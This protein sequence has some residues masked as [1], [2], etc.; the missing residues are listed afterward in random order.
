MCKYRQVL[1]V[2]IGRYVVAIARTGV[3]CKQVQLKCMLYLYYIYVLYINVCDFV[4]FFKGQVDHG[5]STNATPLPRAGGTHEN[6]GG[7][8]LFLKSNL[9]EKGVLIYLCQNLVG[10][11]CTCRPQAP[12]F[13]RPCRHHSNT[14]Q[15]SSSSI[16]WRRSTYIHKFDL[17]VVVV[18]SMAQV[19]EYQLG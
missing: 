1:V 7:L 10:V 9:K 6:Q 17:L 4:G 18:A 5:T 14:R 3:Y 2:P 8:K 16:Q 15:L 12:L 19:V 13:R 11:G